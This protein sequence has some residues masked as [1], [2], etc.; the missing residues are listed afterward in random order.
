M[1]VYDWNG[2]S[3]SEI[4]KIY[5]WNG[6]ANSQIGKVYD[7]NGSSNSLVYSA[8]TVL[9]ENG[10]YIGVSN[11]FKYGNKHG[12]SGNLFYVTTNEGTQSETCTTPLK[13]DEYSKLVFVVSS[14]GTCTVGLASSADVYGT[15]SFVKSM[16]TVTGV[17]V[18]DIS[19]LTGTY[20]LNFRLT[21]T[22]TYFSKIYFE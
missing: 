5:D 18:L 7:N 10:Q 13:V 3:N 4:G 8:E 11:S 22:T 15:S 19:S 21:N 17:N 16:T 14:G 1:A 12:V 20:Y 6:S 9:I 2:S